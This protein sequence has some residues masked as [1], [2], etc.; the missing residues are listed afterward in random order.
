VGRAIKN[1]CPLVVLFAAML[2]SPCLGDAFVVGPTPNSSAETS[3]PLPFLLREVYPHPATMR[4]QQV[5]NASLFTNVDPVFIY[6]TVLSF[7]VVGSGGGWTV[8]NMQINLSTTQRTADSLSL[9]FAENVGPDDSRVLGPGNYRFAGGGTQQLPLD[10]PF[11]YDPRLGNLLVD[12]RIFNGDGA[13][14]LMAQLAFNSPT[15]EVSRVWAPD[16]NASAAT[17]ADTVGLGTGFQFSPVPSLTNH[18]FLCAC[19]PPTNF[20]IV[21]W[22][23]EPYAFILQRSDV[24]GT[25]A[26]WQIVTNRATNRDSSYQRYFFPADTG[27]FSGFFRLFLPPDP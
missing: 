8:T 7:A 6:V 9:T 15:D 21:D 12:V 23:T 22:P 4:Y 1:F 19:T 2:R 27:G 11:R 20:I 24:L 3:T 13:W 25:G 5:Y 16:V 17:G 10:R 26:N 14:S 18:T